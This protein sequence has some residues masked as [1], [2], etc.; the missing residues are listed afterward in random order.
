MADHGWTVLGAGAPLGALARAYAMP[1]CTFV[2]LWLLTVQGRV[3]VPTEGAPLDR[4]R[5]AAAAGSAWDPAWWRAANVSEAQPRA[6]SSIE[7]AAAALGSTLQIPHLVSSRSIEA[8]ADLGGVILQTPRLVSSRLPAPALTSGRWH[9]VQRWHDLPRL[10]GGHTYLV[11]AGS[12]GRTVR[13][14]Q[15]SEAKGFRVS[16]GSW[17]GTAGLVGYHVG[18]VV[19]P[20]LEVA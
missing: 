7:A 4:Y 3:A 15:S 20:S 13:V 2:A 19:L 10:R 16:S 18:A 6:W 17:D 12:D 8:A 11:H 1:C 5:A 14:V 9:V